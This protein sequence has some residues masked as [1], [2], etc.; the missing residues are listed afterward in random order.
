[1]VHF[2][3]KVVFITGASAGIGRSLA[4]E[5]ARKGATLVLTARRLDRLNELA[6]E[7]NQRGYRALPLA[8]DVTR[9]GELEKAVEIARK[10]FGKIDIV[11]ANAGFGVAKNVEKLQLED[12]RR[13]FE[14][15]VF[16][17][18]RTIYATLDELKKS[19]GSLVLVGSVMGYVSLPGSSAYGMSKH[20]IHALAKSLDPELR[21]YGVSVTLIAPGMIDSELRM[22]DNHGQF[23]PSAK[24][25]I[26]PFLVMPTDQAAKKILH[27]IAQRRHE[28]VITLHGKIAVFIQRHF[29]GLM[30]LLTKKLHRKPKGP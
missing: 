4:K 27:A 15:N 17:V 2:Q 20:A 16:G 18:M 25:P 10:T 21:P 24:D 28:E 13:Q 9:D 8:C 12:Y 7:L 14:T 6:T 30:R 22:V 26:P 29:P 3:E 1:M 23:H 19:K 11:I 5:F